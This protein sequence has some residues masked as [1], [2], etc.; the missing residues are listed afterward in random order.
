MTWA[1]SG[2][3]DLE[4]GQDDDRHA[5]QHGDPQQGRRRPDGPHGQEQDDQ[6]EQREGRA[7]DRRLV[8]ERVDQDPDELDGEQHR[9]GLPPEPREPAGHRHQSTSARLVGAAPNRSTK[10]RRIG[11]QALTRRAD[12]PFL[13][14]RDPRAPAALSPRR[15]CWP[16]GVPRFAATPGQDGSAGAFLRVDPLACIDHE[17]ADGRGMDGRHEHADRL[18]AALESAR[19]LAPGSS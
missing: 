13:Q 10:G 6:G 4:D 9:R 19:A 15:C 8:H 3:S 16:T 17:P 12:G 2:S 18:A 11:S 7:A 14:G 1:L 5:E